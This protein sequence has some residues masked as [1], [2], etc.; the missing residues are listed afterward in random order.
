MVLQGPHQRT[1][2]GAA[3]ANVDRRPLESRQLPDR[4]RDAPG[5]EHEQRGLHVGG[6][7]VAGRGEMALQPAG[8][9]IFGPGALGRGLVE[10]GIAEQ[11]GQQAG[12]RPA[13]R[14]EGAVAV[15]G[16]VEAAAAPAVEQR[17]AG[18]GVETEDGAGGVSGQHGHVRD[19]ADVHDHA[20]GARLPEHRVV[21]R[22]HERR[23]L[24]A[25]RQVLA[26][27]IRHHGNAG[28]R[29]DD[30]G[31]A[32]LEREGVGEG[33]PVADGL[34]VA[35]DGGDL[36][37]RDAGLPEQFVDRLGEQPAE[38]DIGLAEPVDLVGA[39]HTQGQQIPPQILGKFQGMGRHQ[40]GRGRKTHQGGIDAVDAGAGEGADEQFRHGSGG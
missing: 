21:K 5:R 33:R 10:I 36:G 19:A 12:V 27:E 2:V 40:R 7:G 26:P 9:E 29:G 1:V 31:I 13:A 23:A 22:R 30:V 34:P 17:V 32:D 11:R 37:G 6:G 4:V 39:R 28:V 38:P 20:V 24:A 16:L 25:E 8:G 14:G 15:H 18:A 3:A 35:A